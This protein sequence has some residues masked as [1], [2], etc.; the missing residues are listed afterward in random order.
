[1]AAEGRGTDHSLVEKL[2]KEPYRFAFFQAV[3]LLRRIFPERAAV[4]RDTS[5][6]REVA[7][8]RTRVSLGFPASQVHQ[9]ARDKSGDEERPP[10]MAVAFMGL[11]GPLGVLPTH[12]TEML[13]E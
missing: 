9:L 6:S 1:M 4:G 11:T 7:H 5:A 3:R 12:Y 2:F 13:I 8:F 10:Q